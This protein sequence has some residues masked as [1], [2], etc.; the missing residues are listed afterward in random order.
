VRL[1]DAPRCPYCAR[2]RLVLAEKAIEFE[3]VEIDLG[4]RPDWV[5]VPLSG[6][7]AMLEE[8]R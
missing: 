2:A 3:R 1:V 6:V 5:Q 7:L 4:N 8:K